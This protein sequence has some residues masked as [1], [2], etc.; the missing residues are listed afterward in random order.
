L[1]FEESS[2]GHELGNVSLVLP[3]PD[4]VGFNGVISFVGFVHRGKIIEVPGF[5]HELDSKTATLQWRHI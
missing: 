4:S 5:G 1:S 2:E 3:H